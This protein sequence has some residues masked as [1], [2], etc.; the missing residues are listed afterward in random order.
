MYDYAMWGSGY[1]DSFWGY[2]YGDIYAGMFAPYGYD[3][4]TGY[5]PQYAGTHPRRTGGTTGQA[6][7][8]A[9][10]PNR[11]RRPARYPKCAAMTAAISQA[12]RSIGASRRSR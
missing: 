4:L 12:C 10:T 3:D 11:T 6:S 8:A 2:G 7:P 5:R 9:A 1:D